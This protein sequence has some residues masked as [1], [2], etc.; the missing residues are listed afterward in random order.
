MKSISNEVLVDSYM[1]A[2]DLQLE[3]EFLDLLLAEIRRREIK[4]PET[5]PN[6]PQ[7]N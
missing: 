4:L 5:A 1:K 6:P 7:V 2:V 3:T